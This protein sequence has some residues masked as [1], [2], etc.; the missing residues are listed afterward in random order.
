MER[1]ISSIGK[2]FLVS[3]IMFD[4][5][6]QSKSIERLSS[7]TERSISSGYVP[8]LVSF[9]ESKQIRVEVNKQVRT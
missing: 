9:L 5:W 4:H 8:I 3:S 6:T 1:S 7:I 2:Y